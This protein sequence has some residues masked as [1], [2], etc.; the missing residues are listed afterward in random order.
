MIPLLAAVWA[1]TADLNCPL[2]EWSR[3]DKCRLD[4]HKR[5]SGILLTGLGFG[6]EEASELSTIGVRS[7]AASFGDGRPWL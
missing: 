2:G 3:L 5:R 6:Q 7:G 4:R 1:D